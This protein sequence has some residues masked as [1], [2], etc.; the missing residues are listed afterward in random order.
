MMRAQHRRALL[1]LTIVI[2]ALTVIQD[3]R[4]DASL[5][6]ERERALAVQRQIGAIETSLAAWRAAQA[7]YV[8]T[9]QG[10]AYWMKRAADR[11][12]EIEAAL[13]Q[14]GNASGS[15]EARR[16]YDAATSALGD[17]N[18]LDGRARDFATNDRRF[19][20]SDLI[21]T[22]A[23]QPT[24]RLTEAMA[25]AA[26]MEQTASDSRMASTRWW[27][28]ALNVGALAWLFAAF[29][30]VRR[31][32]RLAEADAA[33]A[34]A[35]Q[36]AAASSVDGVVSPARPV[37]AATAA[38]TAMNLTSAADL[39]TELGC[40]MDS[41]DMSALF[42]RAAPVLGAKGM[43]LWVADA[44]GT[45]LRP[46]L[47]LGYPER[48]LARIG[49]LQADGDNVT[50]LAFRSKRSQSVNGSAPASPGAIAVPLVNASGCVGVLSAE[51]SRT[52]P[53][54]DTLAVARIIAAQLATVVVPANLTTR[55][56]EGRTAQL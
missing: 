3:L 40:V 7:G 23:V 1:I 20:A 54:Q 41:Q 5:G 35:A 55:L 43:V 51:V 38:P 11:S 53:D 49:E 15:A 56:P 27:R 52:R 44:N 14:L 17:L 4:F 36:E 13:S 47:T 24:Q 37:S 8:A 48:V 45:V 22:D 21:F 12:A 2:A 50:S 33:D 18:G 26:T 32:T 46:S 42:E 30:L 29:L 16:Q 10:P 34:R 39:C 28:L 19:E 31:E 6:H 9:G 25:A